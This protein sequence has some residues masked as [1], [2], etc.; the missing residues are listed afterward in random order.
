MPCE[1][2]PLS[3]FSPPC[4]LVI[5]PWEG[6]SSA[7]SYLPVFTFAS[8]CRCSRCL[9]ASCMWRSQGDSENWPIIQKVRHTFYKTRFLQKRGRIEPPKCPSTPPPAAP[10]FARCDLRPPIPGYIPKTLHIK[11]LEPP[12]TA[13]LTSSHLPF[14]FLAWTSIV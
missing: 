10:L 13:F 12:H 9:R 6:S 11:P 5:K 1:F 2:C 3:S 7:V 4:S 14:R 8:Q